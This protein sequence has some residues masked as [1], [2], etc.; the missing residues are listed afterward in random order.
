MYPPKKQP[1]VPRQP[2][3]SSYSKSYESDAHVIDGNQSDD[4]VCIMATLIG[5]L[6]TMNT[7]AAY[8]GKDNIYHDG[9]DWAAKSRPA[10]PS[11]G[12]ITCRGDRALKTA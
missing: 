9:M 12:V 1:C 2:R 7:L 11:P 10:P 4:F 6:A 8:R 5:P 3:V